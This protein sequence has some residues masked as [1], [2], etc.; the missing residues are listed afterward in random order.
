MAA[1]QAELPEDRRKLIAHCAHA[2]AAL[3]CDLRVGAA[4]SDERDHLRLRLG[5]AVD[6]P[7][8]LLDHEIAAHSVSD[9]ELCGCP[10]YAADE[11]APRS[12]AY[13]RDTRWTMSISSR[14]FAIHPARASR[15]VRGG[16]LILGHAQ[17]IP[18]HQP[19][20]PW[21]LHS[22]LPERPGGFGERQW[23]RQFE[24][25]RQ[26][27]RTPSGRHRERGRFSRRQRGERRFFS[28]RVR[29][30]R[31]FFSQRRLVEQRRL[32]SE[33]GQRW[34]RCWRRGQSRRRRQ[35]GCRRQ[36]RCPQ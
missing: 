6:A 4:R 14:A 34:S 22:H 20:R 23:W 19:V 28:R 16:G 5:E 21:D 15:G 3:S 10:Q 33:R 8:P 7:G 27:G 35:R 25:R 12:G 31:R 30:E 13:G 26:R 2:R 24:R 11:I 36:R 1:R 17:S 32:V 18:A 9:S 29:R